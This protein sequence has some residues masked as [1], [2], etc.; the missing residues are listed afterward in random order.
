MDLYDFD[1]SD[2]REE[3]DNHSSSGG[4]KTAIETLSTDHDRV[5]NK[6]SKM[7]KKKYEPIKDGNI[8]I[9]YEDDPIEYKRLRK[10]CFVN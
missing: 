10:Y 9:R 8:S 7:I 4:C 6:K 1:S 5:E 2:D 3:M